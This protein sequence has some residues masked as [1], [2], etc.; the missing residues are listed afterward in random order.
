MARKV[1]LQLTPSIIYK[2]LWCCKRLL[3]TDVFIYLML[4]FW[5]TTD[6]HK[7]WSALLSHLAAFPCS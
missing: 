6:G 4:M 3:S 2:E 7:K 5:T 1:M